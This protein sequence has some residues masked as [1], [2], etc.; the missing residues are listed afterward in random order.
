MEAMSSRGIKTLAI[1]WQLTGHDEA[2][3]LAGLVALVSPP[4]PLPA[5][6]SHPAPSR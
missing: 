3:H 6:S 5:A 2:W 4:P 1:A